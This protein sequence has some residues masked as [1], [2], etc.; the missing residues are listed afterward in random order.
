MREDICKCCGSECI[1]KENLPKVYH[2]PTCTHVFRNYKDI[3]LH[4]YYNEEYRKKHQPFPLSRRTRYAKNLA[5]TIVPLMGEC[6]A[7]LEIG[8]G[9][10]IMS[11]FLLSAGKELAICEIDKN[12]SKQLEEYCVPVFFDSFVD[13][14][15]DIGCDAVVAA[16]VLE[17]FYHPKDFK[18]KV[19]KL[20][21]GWVFLQVPVKRAINGVVGVPF[22]G[23]Y[24]YFTSESIKELFAPEWEVHY[25]KETERDF[26][27]NGQELIIAFEKKE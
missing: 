13:I 11:G 7:V 9:D 22:D 25:E 12:F 21:A 5:D 14:P 4:K 18:D 6:K 8:A 2:C 10:G 24:Q 19:E 15:D 1:E 16:D 26:T 3:D 27:A 23:H 17:H 20:G